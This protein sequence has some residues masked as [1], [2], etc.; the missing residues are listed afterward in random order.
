MLPTAAPAPHAP[1]GRASLPAPASLYLLPHCLLHDWCVLGDGMMAWQQQE[2]CRCAGASALHK[3]TCN[4]D[5]L[6][7][8]APAT[9]FKATAGAFF[10]FLMVFYLSL[11]VCGGAA[12]PLLQL[13]AAAK[14]QRR[15]GLS[16]LVVT[17][18]TAANVLLRPAPP[19]RSSPTSA[20]P[21]C[22]AC[23]TSRRPRPCPPRW[24]ACST[25]STVGGVGSL[26]HEAAAPSHACREPDRTLDI[27]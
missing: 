1:A 6:S 3:E 26:D 22:T 11:L 9:G 19:R 7:H 12:A 18:P 13:G 16:P 20:R 10:W 17:S 4:C 25:C 5:K 27:M 24:P 23:P 21:A 14:L 8:M 2:G 15:S